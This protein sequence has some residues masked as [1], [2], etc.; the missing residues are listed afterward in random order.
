MS[1]I[2]VSLIHT[3]VS[4]LIQHIQCFLLQVSGNRLAKALFQ[5]AICGGSLAVPQDLVLKDKASKTTEQT[6]KED[7]L[8]T[9]PL[10][11]EGIDAVFL[12]H[13]D[14]VFLMMYPV[15]VSL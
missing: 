5:L 11:S 1:V 10:P 8:T 6:T 13:T 12:P 3:F 9:S 15:C 4:F 7:T 14:N 2:T